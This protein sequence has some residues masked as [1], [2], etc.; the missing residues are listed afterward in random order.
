[1]LLRRHLCSVRQARR[2]SVGSPSI[3]TCSYKPMI[4]FKVEPHGGNIRTMGLFQVLSNLRCKGKT[5]YW[6]R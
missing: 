4:I 6:G 1:M 2:Q 5:A 3:E